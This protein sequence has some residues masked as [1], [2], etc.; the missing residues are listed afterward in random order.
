VFCACFVHPP[1]L[2]KHLTEFRAILCGSYAVRVH[3]SPIEFHVLQSVITKW[4]TQETMK[5]K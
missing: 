2:L 1:L 3:P 5:W 4:R